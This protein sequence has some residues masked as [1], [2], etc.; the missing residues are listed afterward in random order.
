MKTIS[1]RQ[2]WAYALLH[3]GKAVENRTSTNPRTKEPCMPPMCRYRGPVLLHASSG[4]TGPEYQ[5]A[6]GWMVDNDLVE[7]GNERAEVVA[8]RAK[9]GRLVVPRL[10]DLPRGGIVGWGQVGPGGAGTTSGR[11]VRY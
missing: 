6:Y 5:E 8:E 3:L 7:Y 2:P 10:A 11:A 4:C 9:D 1:V